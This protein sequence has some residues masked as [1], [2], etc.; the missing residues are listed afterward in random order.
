M[1]SIHNMTMKSLLKEQKEQQQLQGMDQKKND[2]EL[3]YFQS[4]LKDMALEKI[5]LF[6]EASPEYQAVLK[7]IQDREMDPLSAAEHLV[8][9][10]LAFK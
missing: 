7:K 5:Q 2:Q 6:M 9:R 3:N 10:M 1:L 4:L 8:S